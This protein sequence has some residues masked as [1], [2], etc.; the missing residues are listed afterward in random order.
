MAAEKVDAGA[1]RNGGR[2]GSDVDVG[3]YVARKIEWGQLGWMSALIGEE[4]GNN[5]FLVG[6]GGSEARLEAL[7]GVS[8]QGVGSVFAE[9][10]RN[11]VL[12]HEIV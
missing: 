10:C 12:A 3:H 5:V 9:K 8:G 1:E 7:V 2:V 6:F 11:R 4:V